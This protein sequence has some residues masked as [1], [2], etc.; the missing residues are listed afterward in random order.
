MSS[1]IINMFQSANYHLRHVKVVARYP[2]EDTV[3]TAIHCNVMSRLD[4]NKSF[5]QLFA[6]ARSLQVSS[7]VVVKYKDFSM[8]RIMLLE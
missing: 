1:Q 7:T 8:S 2:P 6:N 4:T 3:K 5:Y